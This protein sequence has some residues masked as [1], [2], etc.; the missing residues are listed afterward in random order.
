MITPA[1]SVDRIA[2]ALLANGLVLRGGFNFTPSDAPPTGSSGAPAAAVLLVG[3][4]G[5][6]PLPHFLR[7]WEQQPQA[8]ANP[9]DTWSREVIGA[10]AQDFGARAI[11]PS[12]KPYLPFQQWAMRAEGLKPSPLGI[13]MHPR[14]GLWHAYRGVLLFDDE[15]PVQ[16]AEAAPHLCDSC[17][18]KPCLKSCPVDAYSVQG[19]AYQSCLAHVGGA[20]GEP[21][22]SGGCLDR[23]ACPYGTGYRYPPEVQAFHM[24]SFARATS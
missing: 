3:Q 16:V 8:I 18:E 21:C 10:V 7:W 1:G 19:F 6:A 14:Y 17:A 15:I 11:S 9:L 4:A 20:N 24:A 12:D 22:R 23:N 13:L 5:A 2:A